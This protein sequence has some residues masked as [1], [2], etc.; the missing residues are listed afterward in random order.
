MPIFFVLYF[1]LVGQNGDLIY[2]MLMGRFP[3]IGHVATIARVACMSPLKP[4]IKTENHSNDYFVA[5]GCQFAARAWAGDFILTPK[6][7]L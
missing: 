3:Q 5:K 4:L 1:F 2:L 7:L 6:V